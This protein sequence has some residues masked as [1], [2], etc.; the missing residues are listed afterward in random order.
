MYLNELDRAFGLTAEGGQN[1]S[2]FKKSS[3]VKRGAV[4]GVDEIINGGSDKP[5]EW[6]GVQG[7][8]YSQGN[9]SLNCDLWGSDG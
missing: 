1:R 3:S 4:K 2:V 6:G 9:K 5:T 8:S 7:K